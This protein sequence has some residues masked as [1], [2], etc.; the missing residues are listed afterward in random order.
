MDL[1]THC[2]SDGHIEF[3]RLRQWGEVLEV[4]NDS[5]KLDEMKN[6]RIAICNMIFPF[7]G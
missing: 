4:K 5:I 7:V 3:G 6:N 2:S 1:L